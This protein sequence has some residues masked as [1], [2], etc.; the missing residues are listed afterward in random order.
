M[1]WL[2]KEKFWWFAPQRCRVVSHKLNSTVSF[3]R[4]PPYGWLK[5]N[6]CGIAKEDKAGCRGFLRDLE[7]MARGIFSGAAG[8]NVVEKAEIET[9]KIALEVFE[10]TSWKCS[11]SLVIEVGSEVVFS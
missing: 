8:T 3:W 2:L 5:L 11:N 6:V 4:P 10:S 7:G 1:G 9:V